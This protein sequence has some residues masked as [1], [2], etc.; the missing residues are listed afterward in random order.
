MNSLV[1]E[2]DSRLVLWLVIRIFDVWLKLCMINL[3]RLDD[4][5]SRISNIIAEGFLF[6]Q[7]IAKSLNLIKWLLELL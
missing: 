7:E 5:I 3:V 1:S 6:F 4:L 2:I